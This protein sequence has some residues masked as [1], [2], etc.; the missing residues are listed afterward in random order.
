MTAFFKTKEL[1]DQAFSLDFSRWLDAAP[2]EK[3]D[4]FEAALRTFVGLLH[5]EQARRYYGHNEKFPGK[6]IFAAN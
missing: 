4:E 1:R 5:A 3:L 2:N 6:D